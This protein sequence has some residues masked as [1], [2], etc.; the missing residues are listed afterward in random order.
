ML[1]SYKISFLHFRVAAIITMLV[2]ITVLT[3][4][5]IGGGRNKS[6]NNFVK[7]EF[8]P[9]RTSQGFTLKSGAQYR[10]SL[11]VS[12]VKTSTH[13]TYTSLVTFQKGNTTYILPNKHKL[14]IAPSSNHSNLQMLN[15]KFRICK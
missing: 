8:K 11:I 5:S 2:G 12:E 14:S 1:K 13:I 7:E 6:K 9:I 4:A 15:L 10:G 3:F